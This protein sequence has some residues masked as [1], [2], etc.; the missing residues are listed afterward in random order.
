ML[1]T[2]GSTLVNKIAYSDPYFMEFIEKNRHW[3][4]GYRCKLSNK[5]NYKER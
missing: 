2:D 4:T 5:K 3:K 1:D